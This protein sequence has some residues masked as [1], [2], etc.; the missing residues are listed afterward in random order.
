[1][2]KEWE[3]LAQTL[4]NIM[5]NPFIASFSMLLIILMNRPIEERNYDTQTFHKT[6]FENLYNSVNNLN[7]HI[8]QN[9]VNI[10][11]LRKL[12]QNTRNL[13]NEYSNLNNNPLRYFLER[14]INIGEYYI[15]NPINI[16]FYMLFIGGLYNLYYRNRFNILNER[17]LH[18]IVNPRIENLI[19]RYK[20]NINPGYYNSRNLR[21]L[22]TF[23]TLYRRR[24]NF[25][26]SYHD[27]LTIPLWIIKRF[28][29]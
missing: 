1:M 29:R 18:N 16:A 6:N 21:F 5:G 24:L 3:F 15:Q 7:D 27:L 26:L 25:I 20:T 23:Y 28:F 10:Q 8:L 2:G 12:A 14:F 9:Y 17:L 22:N 19:E 4:F 13:K 11:H